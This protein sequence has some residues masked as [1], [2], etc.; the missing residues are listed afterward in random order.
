MFVSTL[1]ISTYFC[2][3]LCYMYYY[4]LWNST[5]LSNYSF[6]RGNN[7]SSFSFKRK[8][9]NSPYLKLIFYRKFWKEKTKI[10]Q[11]SGSRTAGLILPNEILAT[12]HGPD[13]HNW[14]FLSNKCQKSEHF[15]SKMFFSLKNRKS[16]QIAI[17]A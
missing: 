2:L 8:I 9:L 17:F 12:P 5:R 11:R 16:S 15:R 1:L 6:Y 3:V 14:W 4:K 7:N 10:V 13:L